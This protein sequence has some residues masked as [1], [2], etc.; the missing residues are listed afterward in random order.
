MKKLIHFA[1]S[2]AIAAPIGAQTSSY[3]NEQTSTTR[4]NDRSKAESR[5]M[6]VARPKHSSEKPL[7][8]NGVVVDKN[9]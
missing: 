4:S 5:E 7:S 9:V 6:A 3:V 8:S 2:L 1:L